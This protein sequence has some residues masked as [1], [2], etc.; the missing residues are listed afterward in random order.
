MDI[1]DQ[2]CAGIVGGESGGGVLVDDEASRS[3]EEDAIGFELREEGIREEVVVA[4]SAIDMDGDDLAG[5]G[6]FVDTHCGARPPAWQRGGG[7]WSDVMV[8]NVHPDRIS[9]DCQGGA[10]R[11]EPDDAELGTDA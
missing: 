11:A 5:A 6:E 9:R 3:V 10:D 2:R 8:E 1:E 7:E 4:F